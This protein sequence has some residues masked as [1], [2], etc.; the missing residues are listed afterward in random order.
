M[1]IKPKKITPFQKTWG[2]SL[3][4]LAEQEAVSEA[5]ILMRVCNLGNPF[6]RFRAPDHFQDQYGASLQEIC[7]EFNQP[8]LRLQSR[9]QFKHTLNSGRTPIT[10]QMCMHVTDCSDQLTPR[11]RFWLMPEH[12]D[13]AQARIPKPFRD[14]DYVW[15]QTTW[16]PGE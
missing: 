6:Q 9:M 15:T 8:K 10:E 1:T 14:P 4:L 16:T 3:K 5:A 11:S 13:Y 12:P 2:I 7:L